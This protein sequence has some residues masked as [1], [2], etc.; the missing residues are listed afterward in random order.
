MEYEQSY[1]CACVRIHQSGLLTVS[2]C[3]RK[4]GGR[5]ENQ[6]MGSLPQLG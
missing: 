2:V 3:C 1:V 5:E 4:R 6:E